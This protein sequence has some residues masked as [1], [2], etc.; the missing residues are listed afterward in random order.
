MKTHDKEKRNINANKNKLG[1][2][3]DIPVGERK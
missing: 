1:R 2:V 3:G